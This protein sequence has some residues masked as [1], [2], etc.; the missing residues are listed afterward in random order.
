M[1]VKKFNFFF[2]ILLFVSLINIFL[3]R[4]THYNKTE[5]NK[6]KKVDCF[7]SIDNETFNA[8]EFQIKKREIK[9]GLTL[10]I[11]DIGENFKTALEIWKIN[12]NITLSIIPFR[13]DSVKISK[14][15]LKKKLPV[16]LHLPM[17]PDKKLKK[18]SHFLTTFQ[19]KEEFYKVLQEDL[20]SLPY[21]QGI[22]NHMGSK[23]T[24]DFVRLSWF[25]DFLKVT[26]LF[27]IDSR[28][29]KTSQ[30]AELSL[31]YNILTGVR[32]Y[33]IDNKQIESYIIKQLSKALQKVHDNNF[34][35]A[36][37]HP[38]PCTIS[39]LKTFFR[40]NNVVVIP[41]YE[42][43]KTFKEIERKRIFM[44]SEKLKKTLRNNY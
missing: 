5:I 25:F 21:F 12:D 19:N 32:D 7:N 8:S 43:L 6:D 35:I 33:F 23:L 17:E 44:K 15:A 29:F 22:N 37:G 2:I 38:K 20:N 27:F 31:K 10:I 16:M 26:N 18:Y 36:I 11:D 24:S 40:E 39:A 34:A 41:A 4:I 14:Y 1:K 30:A 13:K 9:N 28:T 42:G 3:I